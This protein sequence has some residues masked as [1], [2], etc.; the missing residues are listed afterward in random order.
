MKKTLMMM[1]GFLLALSSVASAGTTVNPQTKTTLQVNT[2]CEI[3]PVIDTY[4]YVGNQQI[5]GVSYESVNVRCNDQLPYILENDAQAG[6]L[7]DV[8]SAANGRTYQVEF[9]AAALNNTAWGTAANG[10]EISA[11]GSGE[12]QNYGYTVYFNRAYQYGAPQV[13]TYTGMKT[14]TISF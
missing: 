6:G 11:T 7:V 12:G 9:V 4:I 2:F 1:A 3:N 13:G 5:D 8:T 10:E 14:H